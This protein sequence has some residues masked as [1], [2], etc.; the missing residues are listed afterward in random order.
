MF[1]TIRKHS[2]WMWIIIVAATI[3]SFVI[4]FGPSNRMGGGG[5]VKYNFGSIDGQPI[6][7]DD[8]VAAQRCAYLE[9]FF[10]HR[11]WPDK[12]PAAK[13][14]GFNEERSIYERLL[15][16]AKAKELGI[17]VSPETTAKVAADIIRNSGARSAQEF[18]QQ[19]LSSRDRVYATLDDFGRF[20]S[21][22]LTLQQLA[23]TVGLP[24]DLVTPQEA[25]TLWKHQNQEIS[26]DLV[27]VPASNYVASVQVTP[28]ALKGFFTAQSERYRVPAKVAVNYVEFLVTNYW[29][30]ADQMFTNNVTNVTEYASMV[31][32]QRGSNAFGGK[33]LAEATVQ[34]VT[35]TKR[36]LARRAATTNAQALHVEMTDTE[37]VAPE[38]LAK[39]AQRAGLPVKLSLP[40]DNQSFNPG[41]PSAVVQK[42]FTLNAEN[43]ICEPVVTDDRIFL[44]SL[45]TNIAS[46]IP[47][48]EAVSNRVHAD[49]V[50]MSATQ[51]AHTAGEA[52]QAKL[53]AG[54]AKGEKFGAVCTANQVR[55]TPLNAFSRTS[56][57]I[58]DLPPQVSASLLQ[59]TAFKLSA[60]KLSE[61]VPVTGGGFVVYVKELLPLDEK[62]MQTEMPRVLEQI[63]QTSQNE[64][65][66]A[67]F[68]K[69]AETGL[70]NTPL[71]RPPTPSVGS[72]AAR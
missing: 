59:E 60:G 34:I 31:Y 1:G 47:T 39:A 4:F 9:Y 58:A 71:N 51:L 44:L 8:F 11:Q 50:Q 53:A 26:A 28:E 35:E 13:Q 38:A 12:D 36:N 46:Y 37:K 63:R 2:K 55:P 30:V 20:V 7:R 49:Y 66:Q 57:A 72:S 33:P 23:A 61:Y 24:G 56:R 3:V 67:W 25:A 64:A 42:S 62:K 40:F 65:F 19:V 29:G 68:R 48:F 52:L 10:N 16:M 14:G 45:A 27:F 5:E 32:E 15:L 6:T 41:L 17:Q 43:P 22:F 54:L 21:Q 70:R 18:Q 69:Q